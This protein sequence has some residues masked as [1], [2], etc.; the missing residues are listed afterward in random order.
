MA[1]EPE[2]FQTT[3][4]IILN[5][6]IDLLFLIDILVMFRTE[7]TNS[8]GE[9]VTDQK[10]I[11]KK[12]F[13]GSFSI[14]LLSTIPLDSLAGLF[15]NEKYASQFKLFGCLKLIRIVR[16]N[17]IIRDMRVHQ[18]VKVT[19]KILKLTFF[20]LL[21]VHVQGCLWYGMIKQ[22]KLWMPT[23]NTIYGW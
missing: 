19:L 11:A 15:L 12:Y 2:I 4:N 22:D 13:K 14:D 3:S 10:Y 5:A 21:Y 16:L 18:R 20:L 8:A 7:T 1:F 6:I 23:L 17:R 9:P